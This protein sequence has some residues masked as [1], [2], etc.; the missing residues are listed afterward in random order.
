MVKFEKIPIIRSGQM[1]YFKDDPDRKPYKWKIWDN[2]ELRVDNN[3]GFCNKK[4]AKYRYVLSFKW[5]I[6]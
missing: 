6:I 4:E 2:A 5:R 3:I 1:V